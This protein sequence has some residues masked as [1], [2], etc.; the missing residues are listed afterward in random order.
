MEE[1]WRPPEGHPITEEMARALTLGDYGK[2][3]S[4][5]VMGCCQAIYWWPLYTPGYPIG[6]S[7]TVTLLQTPSRLLGVTA[8]HVIR[9][10]EEDQAREPH[11]LQVGN[12][13]IDDMSARLINIDDSVD[14]ATFELDGGL[15]AQMGDVAPLS[16]WPP[17]PPA[18]GRGILLG[19][20][21]G[22][23]RMTISP[24]EVSLGLFFAMGIAKTVS[25]DQITWKIDREY[26][27]ERPDRPTL[28]PNYELGGISGG[29]LLSQFDSKAGL[30]TH[31][32]AGIIT[33]ASAR[34]EYV[35]AKRAD[36]IREDGTIY[37]SL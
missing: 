27:L 18:E 26:A 16:L 20:F 19:G 8:A 36:M 15:L 21:P 29:P 28:P 37:R 5:R 17:L 13:A 23:A 30:V 6:G 11:R 1:S 32:L 34:L 24:L 12:A 22:G 10:Y 7:G 4:E 25:D 2:V 9:G 31:R 14:L 3:L 35:V 33:E